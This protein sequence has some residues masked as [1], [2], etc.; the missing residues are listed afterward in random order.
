MAQARL[1]QLHLFQ[2]HLSGAKIKSILVPLK[3]RTIMIR[4]ILLWDQKWE[5][6]YI[7]SAYMHDEASKLIFN[8]D[9]DWEYHRL[10]SSQKQAQCWKEESITQP[11]ESKQSFAE[12]IQNRKIIQLAQVQ[13]LQFSFF[14]D[15][16]GISPLFFFNLWPKLKNLVPGPQTPN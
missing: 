6:N 3:R 8:R 1:H 14:V 9:W 5:A 11:L 2:L 16:F 10:W 15:I 13:V 7:V 12:K 4:F